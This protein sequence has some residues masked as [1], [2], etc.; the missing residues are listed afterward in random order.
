M[1]KDPVDIDELRHDAL[2]IERRERLDILEDEFLRDPQWD[3]VAEH[4]I[5]RETITDL[6]EM[7]W[8]RE[9]CEDFDPTIRTMLRL[10]IESCAREYAEREIDK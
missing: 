5:Q 4:L 1:S 6:L 9:D 8:W 3:A 10:A 2:N 7:T